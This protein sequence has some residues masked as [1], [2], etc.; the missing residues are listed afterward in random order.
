L[1]QDATVDDDCIFCDISSGRLPARILYEDAAACAFLDHEPVRPGHT[2]V[3]PRQHVSGLAVAGA[4]IALAGAAE[5]L[6]AT[7]RLLL[8]GIPADGISVFQSNGAVAG[9]T[10]FHMHFHLVPRVAGDGR[11]TNWAGD[12][13][14]QAQLDETHR[15]LL[16]GSAT[17][18][19]R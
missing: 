11:L 7:A 17:P 16:L 2:L 6:E 18:S 13:E 10:V 14:A 5:A 19:E 1:G 15:Q 8:S 12:E 4:A 9:Q 3:V